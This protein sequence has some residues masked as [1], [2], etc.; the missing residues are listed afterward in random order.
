MNEANKVTPKGSH[1]M[2]TLQEGNAS[3]INLSH[4]NSHKRVLRNTNQKVKAIDGGS[5]QSKL[6]AGLKELSMKVIMRVIKDDQ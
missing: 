6:P 5:Q 2:M 3:S 1:D 4:N